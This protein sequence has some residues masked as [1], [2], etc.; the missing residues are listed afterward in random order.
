MYETKLFVVRKFYKKLSISFLMIY[1]GEQKSSYISKKKV[2][3]QI[4]V[5]INKV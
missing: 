4:L 1:T 5:Y 3:I 2:K